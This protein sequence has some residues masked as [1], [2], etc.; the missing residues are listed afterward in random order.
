VKK[1][2]HYSKEYSFE[3]KEELVRKE[4]GNVGINEID[5]EYVLDKQSLSDI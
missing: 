1:T 3:K 2:E 4:K 5:N